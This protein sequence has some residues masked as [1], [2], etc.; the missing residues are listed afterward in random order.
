MI[1][2]VS[3]CVWV[4]WWADVFHAVDTTAFGAAVDGAGTRHL[5]GRSVDDWSR[6]MGEGAHAEPVDDVAICWVAG[7]AGELFVAG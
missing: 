7:T 2:A 5:E 1:V 4:I 3:V 6:E